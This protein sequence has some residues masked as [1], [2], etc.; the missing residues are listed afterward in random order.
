MSEINLSQEFSCEFSDL[1]RRAEKGEGEAEYLLK[2]INKGIAKLIENHESG[3]KIPKK[4]WP[5]YY[6]QKYEI[7]NLW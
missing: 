7:N 3:Q 6:V 5:K 1:Q 2:L 4:Q